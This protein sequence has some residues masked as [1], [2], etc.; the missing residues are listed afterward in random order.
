MA[1][2]PFLVLHARKH[3]AYCF[4][5]SLSEKEIIPDKQHTPEAASHIPVP[6]RTWR[7]ATHPR[8]SQ[9][10]LAESRKTSGKRLSQG[11][12]DHIVHVQ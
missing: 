8:A 10:G 4:A 3:H 11:K 12:L 1:L 7:E 9:L 5:S 6:A 2:L